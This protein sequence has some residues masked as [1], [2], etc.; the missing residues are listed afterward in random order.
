MSF[1]LAFLSIWGDA[2]SD[3]ERCQR[4]ANYMAEH[5]IFGHVGSTVGRFEGVGWGRTDSPRT[6]VPDSSR[7]YELSGDATATTSDGITVRVRSW[8]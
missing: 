6:C 7:G 2:C 3:Q 5:R 4:E 8:R 1:V